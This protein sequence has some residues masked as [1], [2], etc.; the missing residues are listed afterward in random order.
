M[1][2]PRPPFR[3]DPSA[4]L[5]SAA[6]KMSASAQ[7]FTSWITIAAILALLWSGMA[8]AQPGGN[9]RDLAWNDICSTAADQGPG[10]PQKSGADA[11]VGHCMF[12]S[13]QDMAHALPARFDHLLPLPSP[14]ARA[15]AAAAPAMAASRIWLPPHS[16]GPPASPF[17]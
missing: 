2:P 12:C 16:R 14:V 1:A 5:E 13:K 4:A 8:H 3:K 15:S 10:S 7:R 11:H 9:A 17:L 6:M